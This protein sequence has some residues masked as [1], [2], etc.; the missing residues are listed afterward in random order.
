V[1]KLCS[2]VV[3]GS[4]ISP[5]LFVLFINDVTQIFSEN[6]CAC[7]LYADDLK[8]CTVL[9]ADEDCGN[10]QD[11]LNAIYDCSHNWQLGISYKKCN[12]IYIGNTN[13]K[14]H[15]LLNTVYLAVMDEV[16]VVFD[17][18]LTFHT[19]IRKN[20]VRANVRANSI[21]KCFISRDA[22]TLIRA[23]KVYVRPILEYA[24]CT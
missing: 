23:L 24:S 8:L 21:H 18:R 5:L 10:L 1:T 4:V 20:V 12:L 14:P 3:Q 7:K 13:C 9:D 11:K 6:K 16:I 19:H 15:L 22:F 2:G 17:S